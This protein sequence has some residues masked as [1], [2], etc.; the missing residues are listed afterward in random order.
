MEES[1]GINAHSDTIHYLVV[2]VLFAY[3]FLNPK[4]RS[5][6]FNHFTLRIKYVRFVE[7]IECSKRIQYSPQD[8]FQNIDIDQ[9]V[10]KPISNMGFY[11]KQDKY[12]HTIGSNN[13]ISENFKII[14]PQF[15]TSKIVEWANKLKCRFTIFQGCYVS[16]NGDISNGTHII[17]TKIATGPDII[18]GP[19]SGSVVRFIPKVISI[20]HMHPVYGHFGLDILTLL[21]MIPDEFMK[22]AVIIN[23]EKIDYKIEYFNLLN[24]THKVLFIE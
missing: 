11:F 14:I 2:L 22:D 13:Y 19:Q 9:N 5:E 4:I 17:D 15:R 8:V 18:Y 12:M 23:N 21:M 16:S 1:L 7:R 24:L 3:S 10:S 6:V 20:N